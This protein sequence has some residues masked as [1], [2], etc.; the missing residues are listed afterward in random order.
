MFWEW[1]L[2]DHLVQDLNPNLDNFGVISNN[3]GKLNINYALTSNEG[4]Q[5]PQFTNADF[6]HLNAIDYNENLKLITFSSRKTNEIYIINHDISPY[7]SSTDMGD[8]IY[9]WGN[10]RIYDRGTYSNQILYAPH[11]VNW[12]SDFS[13]IIFNNGVNRPEGNY[14]S[15][16]LIDLPTLDNGEYYLDNNQPFEPILST[17]NYNLNGNFYTANQG[18]AYLLENNNILATISTMK[19][20]LEIN[21]VGEIVFDFYYDGNGSIPRTQKYASNY[22]NNNSLIGD[23]NF[24]NMLDIL[25][26]IILVNIIISN[27]EYNSSA[28]M[29]NDNHINIQDIIIIVNIIIS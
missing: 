23:L 3:P 5:P 6:I 20:I 7:E 16:E 13:L 17:T 19:R 9:R 27:T 8:F 18:G 15:I 24:D 2:W 12:T 11:S 21:Q 22:L 14:S 10:P 26:I 28:D 1:Y 29:N 4:P 25:D